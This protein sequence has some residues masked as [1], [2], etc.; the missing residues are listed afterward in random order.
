MEMICPYI[1]KVAFFKVFWYNS[2]IF[3]ENTYVIT[4]VPKNFI[5]ILQ[6]YTLLPHRFWVSGKAST[7]HLA[8]K[9]MAELQR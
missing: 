6:C 1:F 4:G 2:L 7:I 3:P 5:Q 9:V 8:I